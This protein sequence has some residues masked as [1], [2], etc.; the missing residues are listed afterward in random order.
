MNTIYFTIAL[1]IL[2]GFILVVIL[3]QRVR[4]FKDKAKKNE[5]NRLVNELK[6]FEES[7]YHPLHNTLLIITKCLLYRNDYL[8]DTQYGQVRDAKE[9]LE[10]VWSYG[11]KNSN[12][13][14]MNFKR[15]YNLY[16]LT[17]K[18]TGTEKGKYFEDFRIIFSKS[19]EIAGGDI[20]SI[21][22]VANEIDKFHMTIEAANMLVVS[23]LYKYM[24]KSKPD[25]VYI[26][27]LLL[28]KLKEQ[29]EA[30]LQGM[31]DAKNKYG[32]DLAYQYFDP[33]KTKVAQYMI[34]HLKH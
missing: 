22:V 27:T 30:Y 13:K 1:V 20:A 6:S 11:K 16:Q 15:A 10:W 14:Y 21:V 3:R 9:E 25:I 33:R 34:D 2:C 24:E 18:L 26:D 5:E 31:V 12:D 23:E 28:P 4:K 7:H 17:M 8:L 32:Y 29:I 19:E